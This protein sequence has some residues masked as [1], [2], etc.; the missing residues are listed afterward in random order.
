MKDFAAELQQFDEF[1]GVTGGK[2]FSKSQRETI[3]AAAFGKYQIGEYS[4][5]GDLFIQL[6]MHDP[7]DTRFWKGLAATKQMQK[8]YRASL[9][10]WAIFALLSGHQSMGHFH[11]AECYLSL[12]EKE[13]AKKAL[14]MAEKFLGAEDCLHTRI[15]QLKERI[16]G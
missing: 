2:P 8:E 10:A 16:D 12:D 6:I 14:H 15:E 5:A 9:H 11:A 3:Y 1:L 7:Y 13:E 4:Q